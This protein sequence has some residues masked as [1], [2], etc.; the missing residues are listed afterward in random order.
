VLRHDT[1][2]GAL[3]SL[4]PLRGVGVEEAYPQR[5]A[6][7]AGLKLLLNKAEG[8]LQALAVRRQ[9]LAEVELKGRTQ[10]P[11]EQPSALV[12][13]MI[14]AV[15]PLV[16]E[17]RHRTSAHGEL[18]LKRDLGNGRRE[19][20]FVPRKE[21]AARIGTLRPEYRLVFAPFALT[22]ETIVI[23]EGGFS[24]FATEV[25]GPPEGAQSRKKSP[26]SS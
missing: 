26:A 2:A 19:E 10:A 3:P 17:I 8:E 13:K 6:E 11:L 12:E 21:L 24:R 20:L 1:A 9:A 18:T 5:G 15:A 14:A 16:L 7:S 4:T 22:K 25:S 23:G